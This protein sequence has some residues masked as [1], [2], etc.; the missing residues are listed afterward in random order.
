MDIP[1]LAWAPTVMKLARL[2]TIFVL[3]TSQKSK[4]IW[5]FASVHW[6]GSQ[7]MWDLSITFMR[8]HYAVFFILMA[9]FPI[10][11]QSTV[12]VLTLE[13]WVLVKYL[14]QMEPHWNLLVIHMWVV[15]VGDFCVWI[16]LLLLVS[17]NILFLVSKLTSMGECLHQSLNHSL[18]FGL[19][20][21]FTNCF[22]NCSPNKMTLVLLQQTNHYLICIFS[23]NC[24]DWFTYD[25]TYAIPVYTSY[26][27]TDW[28]FD[29]NANIISCGNYLSTYW[30]H[31]S[32]V[33]CWM[34]LWKKW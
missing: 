15:Y 22:S 31:P 34:W 27:F 1:M 28:V 25:T 24:S 11:L 17:C 7:H 26:N 30:L 14:C 33:D 5:V 32:K 6:V 20:S 2:K 3:I 16:S 8:S 4:N 13:F 10:P 21:I 29:C 9:M 23:Y 18:T 12:M 19:P